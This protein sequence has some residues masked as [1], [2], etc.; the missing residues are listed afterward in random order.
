MFEVART[1]IGVGGFPFNI[2]GLGLG[3]YPRSADRGHIVS[4][5]SE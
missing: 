4:D 1:F 3:R 5:Y 2:A